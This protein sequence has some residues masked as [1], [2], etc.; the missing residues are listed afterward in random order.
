MDRWGLTRQPLAASLRTVSQ[1]GMARNVV[2]AVGLAVALAAAEAT[3]GTVTHTLRTI[4]RCA[5]FSSHG[6]THTNKSHLCSAHC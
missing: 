2:L 6:E 5:P 4:R 1:P 3:H